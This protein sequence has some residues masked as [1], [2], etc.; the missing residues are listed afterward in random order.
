MRF[1]CF[2]QVFNGALAENLYGSDLRQEFLELGYKLFNDRATLKSKFIAADVFD[3][4]SGLLQLKGQLSIVYAGAFFHLFV[5]DEQ[6][7]VAK[8]ILELLED[9]PTTL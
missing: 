5:Y 4:S 3:P 6:V 9:K 1:S 8:R 2:I 7:A